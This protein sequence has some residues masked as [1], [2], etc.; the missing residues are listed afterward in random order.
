MPTAR[1]VSIKINELSEITDTD[2]EKRKSH[3]NSLLMM[4]VGQFL[5]HDLAHTPAQEGEGTYINIMNEFGW[6][7]HSM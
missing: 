4:Q 3:V 7:D 5:D 1:E 6:K 2:E